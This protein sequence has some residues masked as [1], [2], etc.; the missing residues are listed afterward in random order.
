MKRS[1]MGTVPLP[2]FVRDQHRVVLKIQ[3]VGLVAHGGT[4]YIT[5]RTPEHIASP[6]SV[7]AFALYFAWYNF[8]R[9]PR[10]IRMTPAM[11]AEISDHVWMIMDD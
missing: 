11:E 4:E 10:T 6:F 5:Y 3:E 9:I 1:E 7:A 2:P 8:C